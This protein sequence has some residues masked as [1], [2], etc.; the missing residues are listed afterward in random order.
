[1]KKLLF[2]FISLL[3]LTEGFSQVENRFRG[4]LN[5]FGVSGTTPNYIITGFFNDTQGRYASDSTS[6][7]DWLY[8]NSGDECVRF[9]VDSIISVAGGIVNVRVV[10]VDDQTGA[11]PTGIGGLLSETPNYG[12]P[13]FVAG[14][15]EDLLACMRTH[16]TEKVDLITAA[17]NAEVYTIAV[18]SDTTTI[19]APVAGDFAYVDTTNVFVRSEFAWL[20]ISGSSG[21]GGGSGSTPLVWHTSPQVHQ[22]NNCASNETINLNFYILDD[23]VI[24][25]AGITFEINSSPA[26]VTFTQ[27]FND[28]TFA[29]IQSSN[30]LTADVYSVEFSY[31]DW[32]GNTITWLDFLNVTAGRP[33]TVT[34][35]LPGDSIL[36]TRV[37]GAEISRDTIDVQ[38]PFS[39]T[40]Q[41]LEIVADE[42][43][44]AQQG[45]NFNDALRWNGVDAYEPA[46]IETFE[47]VDTLLTITVCN[48]LDTC[49]VTTLNAGLELATRYKTVFDSATSEQR[50]DIVMR[51]N[52]D[53]SDIAIYDS[54]KLVVGGGEYGGIFITSEWL[55][56]VRTVYVYATSNRNAI[57]F[58]NVS[59]ISLRN[60]KMVSRGGALQQGLQS[61][62]SKGIYLESVELDSFRIGVL[63]NRSQS[64]IGNSITVTNS[65]L[66]GVWAI[67]SSS[68]LYKS[69]INFCTR[70]LYAEDAV[71]L[72]RLCNLDNNTYGIYATLGSLIAAD[73]HPFTVNDTTSTYQTFVGRGSTIAVGDFA[74]ETKVNIPFNT[75]TGNGIIYTGT[76]YNFIEASTAGAPDATQL[77]MY[78]NTDD[79]ELKKSDGSSWSSIGGGDG[80]VTSVGLTLPSQFSVTG[81]PVTTSGTLA[82]AW[83]NQAANTVLAGPASGADAAPT[84]RSLVAADITAGG[85]IT[86]TGTTNRIPVFAGV[87][88]LANSYLLQSASAITLDA[89]KSFIMAGSGTNIIMNLTG[90]GGYKLNAAGMAGNHGVVN[91]F[92]E[93]GVV[94]WDFAYLNSSWTATPNQ[95]GA[96]KSIRFYNYEQSQAQLVLAINGNTGIR[97]GVPTARLHLPGGTTAAGTG[98]AKF[99]SGPLMTTPEV[100]AVEFNTDR[101]YG[102]ITTGGARRTFAWLTD[103]TSTQ[104]TDGV[105]I[106][107]TL[108][109]DTLTSEAILS[110]STTNLIRVLTGLSPSTR[111]G[112][113]VNANTNNITLNKVYFGLSTNISD[114][115]EMLEDSLHVHEDGETI[116]FIER[117]P[118]GDEIFPRVSAEVIVSPDGG[119]TLEARSNGMYSSGINIISYVRGDAVLTGTDS[120]GVSFSTLSG[121]GTLTYP[122]SVT[123]FSIG[124]SGESGDLDGSGHYTIVLDRTATA[125]INE[126][127]ST[128][129]APV[130]NVINTAAQLGGGP[131]PAAPFV[132]DEGSSPQVQITGLGAGTGTG[133]G[134]ISIRILN[135]NAFSNWQISIRP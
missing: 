54:T 99:T 32:D 28:S 72:T 22:L 82:G 38:H 17:I 60:L 105:T 11:F 41:E 92:L 125:N 107:H 76:E 116:D 87:Q 67:T 52:P 75:L 12:F 115:L 77:K 25:T 119:N 47:F 109:G 36:V 30:S 71:V 122:D 96:G 37:C 45:A 118:V 14:L 42:L 79:N 84:F 69:T 59:N 126:G 44:L 130:I 40:S 124:I 4:T 102:T 26:T 66:Y 120:V 7:G 97:V 98:P 61:I 89:G 91:E 48:N 34:V 129:L 133:A 51:P 20:K 78:F 110:D 31:E 43:K 117:D 58:S 111:N 10:D 46:P 21:G 50:I 68:T 112:L 6:L 49:D 101:W 106:N 86:G 113:F 103:I 18:V 35:L 1:M 83:V 27:F 134:D 33:D 2:L 85:G 123:L 95:Y 62:L 55:D 15:S 135:L 127:V 121:T 93:N 16:F 128:M 13:N 3:F 8:M 90:T 9:Q 114:V 94:K 100:G 23:T 80:T 39:T 70:G 88:A 24:N 64:F 104:A 53:G 57:V 63:I 65:A 29:L 131:T 132:Y 19:A 5:V 73:N 74:D 108:N 81:S 56:T